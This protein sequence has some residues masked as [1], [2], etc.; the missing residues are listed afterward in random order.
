[1]LRFASLLIV[2]LTLAQSPLK[3]NDKTPGDLVI[4]DH[5]GKEIKVKNWQLTT[6][7]RPLD[8]LAPAAK[9]PGKNQH[10]PA[11]PRALEFREDH[12]TTFKEGIL[13]LIP[14]ASLVKI[15]YDADKKTV[16]VTYR[17]VGDK[18]E[19]VTGSTK[20]L[21]INRLT[22]EG[23][24][25]LGDLGFATVKFLGGDAK[26]G[27]RG[28]RFPA[29]KALEAT[30]G[31]SARLIAQDKEKSTHVVQ[32]LAVLVKT[33]AGHQSLPF[34]MFKKTVKIDLGK[35]AHFRQVEPEDKKSIAW[36]FEVTLTDGASHT[37]TL[38][39][40]MALGETQAT[41]VGLIGRGRAGYQLFPPHTIAELTMEG[42]KRP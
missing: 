22:I 36:E 33:N 12:S 41:L 2:G 9:A 13:T 34:L 19:Q 16:A 40:Q 10:G 39:R 24:A 38:L 3:A 1:M 4:V 28:L 18:E 30:Q 42:M 27:V 37:L 11:G 7:T 15:D 8:W 26:Q 5:R 6:G 23:D 29:P 21:G 17:G 14:L 25:D 31:P 35:I 32:G 20:Y